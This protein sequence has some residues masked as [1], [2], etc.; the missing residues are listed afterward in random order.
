M[1]SRLNARRKEFGI[2]RC[3]LSSTPVD[4]CYFKKAGAK[5]TWDLLFGLVLYV[6]ADWQDAFDRYLAEDVHYDLI[7]DAIYYHK[8]GLPFMPQL[9]V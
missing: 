6:D 1:W 7:Q 2:T 4:G 8:N 5:G 9:G 3:F